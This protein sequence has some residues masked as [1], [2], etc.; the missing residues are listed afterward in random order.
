MSY[1]KLL[2]TSLCSASYVSWQRGT[3]RICTAARRAAGHSATAAVDRHLP[4][5][6]PAAANPQQHAAVYRWD[7]HTDGRTPYR[8][9]NPAAYYA[10]GAMPTITKTTRQQQRV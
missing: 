9:I 4:P 7:R 5:A 3:A 10:I 8:Y 1:V 6:G 2:N